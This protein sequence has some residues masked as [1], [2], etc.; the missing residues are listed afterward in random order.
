MLVSIA[1]KVRTLGG[2]STAT[3]SPGLEDTIVV[4]TMATPR[5]A[6]MSRD[7]VLTAVSELLN[8]LVVEVD[9]GLGVDDGGDI[10]NLV[11]AGGDD[12]LVRVIHR[13]GTKKKTHP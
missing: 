9:D 4:V 8:L 3:Y 12:D 5:V 2:A 6:S 1:C 7:S 11:N 13:T 10:M